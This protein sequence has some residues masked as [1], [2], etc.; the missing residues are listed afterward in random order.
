MSHLKRLNIKIL[1]IA[2]IAAIAFLVQACAPKLTA[3]ESCNFVMSNDSQRVSWGPAAPVILYVDSSVP[4]EFFGSIQNAV[5][6]WNQTLGREVLKIG[7]WSSAYPKEA[8]D[9]VNVIYFIKD[10]SDTIRD[11]QAIT[12][13]HWAGDRIFEADIRVNGNPSHFDYFSGPTVVPNRV[14]FESLLL[15]ELGHVLGLEHPKV[16]TVGT[17]MARRLDNATLR[18][19]PAPLDVNDLK[20][21]Y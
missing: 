11:K 4:S 15:H 10:W 18:R 21:E 2:F 12:T 13:I 5:N 14:D 19:V 20:C 6:T 9:G 17:V 3:Q 16:E 7:G 1:G 8:Q